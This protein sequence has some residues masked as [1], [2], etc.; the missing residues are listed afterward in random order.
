[1]IYDADTGV[2]SR[3]GVPIAGTEPE[4]RESADAKRRRLERNAL[5]GDDW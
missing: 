5:F 3:N 4:S 1:V 2:T